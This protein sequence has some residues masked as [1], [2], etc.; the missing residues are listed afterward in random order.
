[1]LLYYCVII[2]SCY[3]GKSKASNQVRN[4]DIYMYVGYMSLNDAEV[5]AQ[6]L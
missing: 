2:L 5:Y 6:Y 4:G 3:S 1:M